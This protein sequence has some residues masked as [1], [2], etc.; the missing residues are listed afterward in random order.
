MSDHSGIEINA[1]KEGDDH[2]EEP[3]EEEIKA[4]VMDEEMRLMKECI[5][6]L[7]DGERSA[8][9]EEF[10][11]FDKDKSGYIT[12]DELSSVLRDLGVYKTTEAEEHGVEAMFQM[13]DK[14]NDN[15]IDEEEFLGMMAISMKLPM[16]KEQ[17]VDA[18]QA[19]DA[20]GNGTVDSSE[21]KQA[22]GNL[23]PKFL[24]DEECDELMALVDADNDGT[25]VVDEFV[26]FFL[27]SDL[28]KGDLK[29]DGKS[30]AATP[31]L[32]F[33]GDGTGPTSKTA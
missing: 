33:S 15:R 10:R 16:T 11:L 28:G 30:P 3:D 5:A 12:R 6:K 1:Q 18:F 14:S 13:F 31:V 24:S 2:D 25:L 20:D 32:A 21:L 26:S 4:A 22:L 8:L 23:G 19:F 17:L 29:A 9:V 7:S 27:D